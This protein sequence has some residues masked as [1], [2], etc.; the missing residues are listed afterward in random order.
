V[1]N[2]R[3]RA[4]VAAW[5][6]SAASVNSQSSRSGCQ[7]DSSA[8]NREGSDAEDEIVAHG[9][10]PSRLIGDR[11]LRT[12]VSSPRSQ[13]AVIGSIPRP[14][15]PAR[16][17]RTGIDQAQRCEQRPIGSS[18]G[19]RAKGEGG[20][21]TRCPLHV[22]PGERRIAQTR[23]SPVRCLAAPPAMRW[24]CRRLAGRGTIGL[25]S[26]SPERGRRPSRLKQ[27]L[28]RPVTGARPPGHP[29]A[30]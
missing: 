20:Q 22:L 11:L 28:E 7:S 18:C 5:S 3:V 12:Q 17:H 13:R 23:L 2:A 8:E 14:Q 10:G 16:L 29:L 9:E 30:L 26:S 24:R 6:I 4:Q 15:E 25:R 21:E 1:P 19:V 27:A